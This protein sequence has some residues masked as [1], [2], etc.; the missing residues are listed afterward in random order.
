[1]RQTTCIDNIEC[2]NCGHKFDGAAAVN[3][4][5]S[6]LSTTAVCPECGAELDVSVSVEYM[7][8]WWEKGEQHGF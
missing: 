5:M 6:C 3:Y 4:D 1:M 2:P 8:T 7:A